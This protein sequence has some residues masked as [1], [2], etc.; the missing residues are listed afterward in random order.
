MVPSGEDGGAV[1][2]SGL[3]HPH[4]SDQRTVQINVRTALFL[5]PSSPPRSLSLSL[6]FI[7]CMDFLTLHLTKHRRHGYHVILCEG[8][9]N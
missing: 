5:L 1:S 2:R 3:Q 8:R 9:K 4:R 7:H 6:S